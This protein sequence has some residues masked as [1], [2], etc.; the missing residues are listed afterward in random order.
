MPQK[1]NFGFF[2]SHCDEHCITQGQIWHKTT[3][4]WRDNGLG[5]AG[6]ATNIWFGLVWCVLYECLSRKEKKKGLMT[7]HFAWVAS[8]PYNKF[9]AAIEKKKQQIQRAGLSADEKATALQE[10]T[11]IPTVIREY[12][13]KNSGLIAIYFLL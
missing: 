11:R 10:I 6:Q 2:F 7:L 12:S 1:S 9:A 13:H 8:R 4:V 3:Y 5:F